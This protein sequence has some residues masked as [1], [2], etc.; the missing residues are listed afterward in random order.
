MTGRRFR[1]QADAKIE[2][3]ARELDELGKRLEHIEAILTPQVL[4][5]H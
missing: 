3:Q 5:A 2:A 1:L 4:S